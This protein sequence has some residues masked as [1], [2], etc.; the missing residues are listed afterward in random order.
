[1]D[2]VRHETEKDYEISAA[3]CKVGIWTAYRVNESR[4]S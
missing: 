1:M 4:C 3:G 2:E